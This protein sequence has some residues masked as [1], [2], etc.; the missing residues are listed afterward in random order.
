MFPEFV[1]DA[2]RDPGKP[3]PGGAGGNIEGLRELVRRL[4]DEMAVPPP[5]RAEVVE[6]VL[7]A[8][9]PQVEERVRQELQRTL[10]GGPETKYDSPA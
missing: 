8:V 2:S 10:D 6:Y 9:A 4:A 1:D 7:A 5:R 3:D